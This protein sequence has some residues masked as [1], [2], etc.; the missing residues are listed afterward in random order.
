M[1][2]DFSTIIQIGIIVPDAQSVSRNLTRFLGWE[3]QKTWRSLAFPAE[4]IEEKLRTSPAAWISFN[5]PA[6]SWKSSSR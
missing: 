3:T 6:W 2:K 1:K 5:C 4:S